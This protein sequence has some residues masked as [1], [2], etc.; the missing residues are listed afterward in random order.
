[1][2]GYSMHV[3]GVGLVTCLGSDATSSV[4]GMR[5]GLVR[6]TEIEGV[7][8]W[9]E[10]DFDAPAFGAPARDLCDG[11]VHSAAWV[12]LAQAS[13]GDLRRDMQAADPREPD[14]WNDTTLLW[15]LPDLRF[16]R[17]GW[18]ED[19]V[20]ALLDEWCR[21]VLARIA[22]LR[23]PQDR[24]EFL[25][26]GAVGPALALKR[27]ASLL[28][29]R[30]A[31][32]V[33]VLAT[34]SWLDRMSVLDLVR[35]DRLA[36]DE[37]PAGLVPGEA[38]AC[39]LIEEMSVAQARS[40]PVRAS[41]AAVATREPESPLPGEEFVRE[42][43][44]A[45][46]SL[47]R[48]LARVIDEALGAAGLSSLRGDVIVDLNGEEWRALT[49]GHALPLLHRQLRSGAYRT[50]VPA[51]SFGDVGAVAGLIGLIAAT[52]AFERRYARGRDALIPL[53]ADD[54]Q[55]AAVVASAASA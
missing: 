28:Q 52:R 42:H 14:R 34:D 13:I 10:E 55:V 25:A 6:R 27:A 36:T 8:N 48:A 49:W 2:S 12:R 47:G 35:Q 20:P 26:S 24:V 54:A 38:G 11:F 46:P 18:P 7:T 29:R 53:V 21:S 4:A 19:D 5:A 43:V 3:T 45:T 44:A 22:G 40:V 9:D 23:L 33:L 31:K 15:C 30:E 51:I 50:I 1:V 37:R 39:V 17:F 32:H 16:E 41:I